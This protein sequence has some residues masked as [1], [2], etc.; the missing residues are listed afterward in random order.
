MA[1][2]DPQKQKQWH[3]ENWEKI[4]ND[5]KIKAKRKQA[6]LHFTQKRQAMLNFIKRELACI[7]CGFSFRDRPECCDFHH[8]DPSQKSGAI[9]EMM[10]GR[11]YEAMERVME[12]IAKCDPLCANC[13]RTRHNP[14]G[15]SAVVSDGHSA[16]S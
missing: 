6:R 14:Q 15:G 1:Y 4:K 11:D 10:R 16:V 5:P 7:D 2:R 9:S 12:E 8:R 3:A 13:H